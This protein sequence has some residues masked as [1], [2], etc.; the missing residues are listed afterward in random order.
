MDQNHDDSSDFENNADIAL[1]VYLKILKVFTHYSRSTCSSTKVRCTCT[2][3]IAEHRNAEKRAQPM[4]QYMTSR[5]LLLK[6]QRAE[7]HGRIFLCV[8]ISLLSRGWYSWFFLRASSS[9]ELFRTMWKN[10]KCSLRTRKSYWISCQ[11]T[12]TY[13][14][15]QLI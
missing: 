13:F 4:F 12:Q 7:D 10:S 2:L 3:C 6:Q 5:F 14:L 8:R 15:W 1:Q 9:F 11:N